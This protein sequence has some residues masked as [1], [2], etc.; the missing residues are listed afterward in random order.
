MVTTRLRWSNG[1]VAL[2]AVAHSL[3]GP[4]LPPAAARLL[5]TRRRSD[6]CA[7]P[8]TSTWLKMRH[9]AGN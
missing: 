8:D 6:R 4:L 7:S 1:T 2:Q 3:I 5:G 9:E